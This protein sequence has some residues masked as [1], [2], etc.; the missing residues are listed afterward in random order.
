MI[1][2]AIEKIEA[3]TKQKDVVVTIGEH[4]FARKDAGLE[5][6]AMPGEAPEP[7][8]VQS[9]DGI[10][11]LVKAELTSGLATPFFI[12][13]RSFNTVGVH[14][15]YY[16]EGDYRR[17]V[18]ATAVCADVPGFREG[19]MDYDTVMIKLRSIFA[20]TEETAYL[21]ELL[22]HVTEEEN[23]QSEDN[24]LAQSVQVYKGI[25]NKYRAEVR[26]RVTLRPFRTFL[27][28][29]QPES[30]FLIRLKEGRQ[31]GFFEADGGVWKLKARENIKAYF[32]D[33]LSSEIADG[34]VIVMI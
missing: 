1:K 23:I 2:E 20:Q 28:V 8:Q 7:F 21:L 3:M 14:T 24:G 12:H 9:L 34:M 31:I 11:Q 22:S 17:D 18:V 29:E 27:E 5:R 13:I 15:N 10:V 26:P 6:I 19:F 33:K 4:T 16:E 32:Q 30:E 25:A